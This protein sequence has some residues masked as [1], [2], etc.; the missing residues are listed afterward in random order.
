M[1][2]LWAAVY[3]AFVAIGIN[4]LVGA[5]FTGQMIHF[6]DYNWLNWSIVGLCA[7]AGLIFSLPRSE[8]P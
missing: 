2:A 4:F 3:G 7:L 6:A 1:R 5:V 8:E